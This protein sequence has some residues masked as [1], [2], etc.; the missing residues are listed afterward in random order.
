M[1]NE[2]KNIDKIIKQNM[3]IE[4]PSL[5][6]TEKVMHQILAS[7]SIREKALISLLQKHTL[8]EPSID[9]TSKVMSILPKNS[10]VFV[11]KPV[12]SKN[13]WYL[14]AVGFILMVVYIFLNADDIVTSELLNSYIAK[15]GTV[16]SFKIPNLLISPIFA[17]S[18][19]ALSS[20]LL[21][22]YFLRNRMTKTHENTHFL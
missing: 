16:F 18:M 9:F 2:S 7:E 3:D 6:F 19:F 1:E 14:L 12:I 10:H 13:V 15:I 20:L 22:D 5:E 21:L 4:K 17:L 8:K 11:Y